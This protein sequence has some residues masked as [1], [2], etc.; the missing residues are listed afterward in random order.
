MKIENGKSET[1][2]HFID[3]QDAL[4][5]NKQVMRVL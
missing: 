2:W 3:H 5:A 1:Q 4:P